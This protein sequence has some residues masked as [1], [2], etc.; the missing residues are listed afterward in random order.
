MFKHEDYEAFFSQQKFDDLDGNS[1]PCT[2][3]A[4]IKDG[5]D[6][7]SVNVERPQGVTAYRPGTLWFNFDRLSEDDGKWV[8]ESAVRS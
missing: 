4:Y 2:A 5:N 1:Y 8:Y 7:V 3:F 6:K